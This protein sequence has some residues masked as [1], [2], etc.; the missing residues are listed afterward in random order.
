MSRSGRIGVDV[1]SV[2]GRKNAGVRARALEW[3]RRLGQPAS[4]T[5]Y[6]EGNA[7]RASV[8][9]RHPAA[10]LHSEFGLRK[11]V[12][13]DLGTVFLSREASPLSKGGLEEGLLRTATY[14]VYDIDDALHHDLR[15]G[16]FD[17]LFSKASKA[18]RAVM[19]ADMV[20]TGNE[21]L[22]DWAS[23][24]SSQVKVIPTCVDPAAYTRKSDYSVA[25]PPRLVWLGTRYGEFYLT[26]LAPVLRR[27]HETLGVRL[28]IVGSG[29]RNLPLLGD[30]VDRIP[31]SLDFVYD[32]LHAF[33]VGLMPLHDSPYERGKCAYK[34][35]EYGAAGLPFIG[36]PVGANEGLLRAVG[37]PSPQT[38]A[39]WTDAVSAMIAASSAA[40]RA[41]ADRQLRIVSARYSFDRWL[42]EWSAA[43]LPCTGTL[44]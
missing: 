32:Q 5:S 43:V 29:T 36:T 37:A 3:F 2:Y 25:D 7:A 30:M 11:Q 10:A 4:L 19:S 33:D 34:L 17:L 18:S 44:S 16:L 40:R 1:F 38:Q 15:G 8:F 27:L 13:H 9:A 6:F 24:F 20:L 23:H 42:R 21:Y 39:D 14:G 28:V 41:Q 22:A 31:W 12:S 26:W 35:L